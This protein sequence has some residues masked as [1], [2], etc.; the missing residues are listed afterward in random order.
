MQ[1]S[2][3]DFDYECPEHLIA[4]YPAPDRDGSKLLVLRGADIAH[5][6]FTELPDLVEAGDL[7]VINT[8]KVIKA[9]LKGLRENG[10]AAEVLLVQPETDGSWRAMVHPGG[11]LKTGRTISFGRRA[12]LTVEEVLGGGLRRVSLS[13]DL[14]WPELMHEFGDV[15]LPPYIQR[16]PD[17]ADVHRYQTIFGQ[18]DGSIAA[19]TA[20][21]HFT[22]DT[23]HRI[24]DQGASIVE[25][26]LHVGPGTFKPV[27]TSTIS[28]HHMHSEWFS[29]PAETAKAVSATRIAGGRV[30]AVGTTVT[31]IL[32]TVAQQ[33]PLV[34]T[35]GWTD[36]FVYPPYKFQVVDCLFTNFHLPRST[37]LMLVCAF[38]G[39]EHVMTAYRE[40]VAQRYRLFSYGD[41]MVLL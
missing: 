8:S 3:D 15:P 17:D 11:K 34:E 40:A 13:G 38:G 14:G 9:R 18:T 41:A 36:L 25:T 5:K 2:V 1:Y 24:R 37:L 29:L 32:E 7:V 28:E 16:P 35:S 31:R 26:V 27:Q 20:G 23:L 4:Q 19:P 33:G 39:Y 22:K 6:K 10:R 21:L 12:V 30:W